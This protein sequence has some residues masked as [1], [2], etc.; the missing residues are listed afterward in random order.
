MLGLVLVIIIDNYSL[1]NLWYIL[2]P[3]PCGRNG[4]GVPLA[5]TE[6]L[7]SQR[8]IYCRGWVLYNF[9]VKQVNDSSRVGSIAL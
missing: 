5:T 6:G 9:S 4:I 3:L 8:S 1:V 2:P 7:S